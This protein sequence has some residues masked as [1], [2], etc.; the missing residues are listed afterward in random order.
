LGKTGEKR[1][2]EKHRHQAHPLKSLTQDYG[3]TC[4]PNYLVAQASRLC[5]R[6]LKVAAADKLPV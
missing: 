4:N 5:D 6:K 1:K 3:H 2:G